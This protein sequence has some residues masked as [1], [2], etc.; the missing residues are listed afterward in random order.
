MKIHEGFHPRGLREMASFNQGKPQRLGEV[1]G[2]R[3]KIKVTCMPV[4]RTG[5]MVQSQVPGKHRKHVLLCP[6]PACNRE[7]GAWEWSKIN[8]VQTGP[9]HLH[10]LL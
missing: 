2:E 7:E 8:E 1:L 3:G 10:C 9:Y 6:F 5:N 4:L